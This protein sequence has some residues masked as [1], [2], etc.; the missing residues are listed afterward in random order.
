MHLRLAYNGT[1]AAGTFDLSTW[2]PTPLYETRNLAAAGNLRSEHLDA[3]PLTDL[4]PSDGKAGLD[5][6]P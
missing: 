5:A 1:I 3:A 6:E 4:T 2:M